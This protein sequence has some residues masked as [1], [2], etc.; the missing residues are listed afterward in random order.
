MFSIWLGMS[1]RSLTAQ[2]APSLRHRTSGV[3]C[4]ATFGKSAV[5]THE[6]RLHFTCR[7]RPEDRTKHAYF[8]QRPAETAAVLNNLSDDDCRVLLELENENL[9]RGEMQR[10]F[11]RPGGS[12]RLQH[13]EACAA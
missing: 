13:L 7:S 8:L 3:P 12:V 5:A 2:V 10:I 11:P 6:P 4:L 9:R 1:R